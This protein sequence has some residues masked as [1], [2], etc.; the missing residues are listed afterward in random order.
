M[1]AHIYLI[2][3]LTN[4]HAGSGD[5]GYGAVDKMI[6]L[7]PAT[8]HPT[9]FGQSLKGAL[10]EYFSGQDG[11]SDN[12]ENFVVP[13]F[14]SPVK[15]DK[16]KDP[17]QGLFTF[18]SADLLAVPVPDIDPASPKAFYLQGSNGQL[19]RFI[20]KAKALQCKADK[21]TLKQ[22]LGCDSWDDGKFKAATQD[23][24]VLARN[25]L[26]NGISENLWYEQYLPH[27][28]VFGAIIFSS[29]GGHWDTFDEHVDG[30]V[31]QLGANATV[32]YGYCQF[33]K[34]AKP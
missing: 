34:I 7:D 25:Y 21:E 13:V 5:S 3:A 27:Q 14:G 8:R 30:K 31:I 15:R 23:I 9:I 11:H 26:N 2:K 10:R 4:L 24:P 32:G 29:S 20:D 28:S 18:L 1:I 22:K 19:G 16:G 6:Q 12:G 17:E 33:E